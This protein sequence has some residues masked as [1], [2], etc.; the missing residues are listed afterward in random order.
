V[1]IYSQSKINK[2]CQPAV[3]AT[4]YNGMFN[5]SYNYCSNSSVF[6]VTSNGTFQDIVTYYNSFVDFHTNIQSKEKLGKL[7]IMLTYR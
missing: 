2:I 1:F 7:E 6:S 3:D 5:Y 4:S